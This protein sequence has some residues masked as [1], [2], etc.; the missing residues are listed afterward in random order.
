MKKS[1]LLMMV[2][3]SALIFFAAGDLFAGKILY[4]DFS[5]N[6]L[7]GKKWFQRN[8]VREIVGGEFVSKIGNRSPG[9][10]AEVA[11]GVFRNN[12]S[13]TNPETIN[14]IEC[15][16]TIVDTKLD[17]AAGPKSFARIAGYFYS[18]NATGGATGDIFAQIMIGDQGNG[19]LEAFWEV[20]EMLTDDTRAW[21][22]IGSGTISDFNTSIIDPP[23]K[24]KLSYDGDKTFSFI[25]NE[26]YTDS[27]IGPIKERYAV[28]SWKGISTGINATNGSNNGYVS[29]KFDNVYIND[30]ITVYD[31]FDSPLIDLTKWNSSEWVR[32]PSNGYLRVNSIGYGSTQ[33]ANTFLTEGDAPYLEAR[34]F[35][36]SASQLSDGA[37]GIGRLQGYYYNDSRGP[38]SGQ[39]YN[40]SE[41]D[42]FAQIWLR[43]NSD[44]TLSANANVD[45]S[46]AADETD[47]TNL[48][49]HDFSVPINLDTYYTL[50]IRFEGKKLIFGC[51]G[52][53]VEYNIDTPMYPAFGEHRLLRSRVYLDSGE[54]GYIKVRFDDVYIEKKGEFNPSIPLLLLSE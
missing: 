53:R 1:Q 9:M 15:E 23:Y 51:G 50:S 27:Y 35:I 38:G 44:G 34:V 49:A 24:V 45:R 12:L 19:K 14:S 22:V 31:D 25:V 32:E 21:T 29:A 52:E 3:L 33:T 4:D 5:S 7:D 2:F 37:W 8:Y 26:L 36:D 30:E 11:P 54:T 28:T 40:Q 10:G 41:G 16:I 18:K 46:N 39:S 17:S 6:Y 42:I 48:F 47:Y 43:Y 13:F 20:Q